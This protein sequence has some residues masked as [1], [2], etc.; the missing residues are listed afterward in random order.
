VCIPLYTRRGI[1]AEVLKRVVRKPAVE[2][3][4]FSR[5]GDYRTF[6]LR[7]ELGRVRCPTLVL[8]GRDDPITPVRGAE[9]VVEH[10]PPEVMR[11]ECL[12]DAGHG[13]FW[14][15]PDDVVSIIKRFLSDL[16]SSGAAAP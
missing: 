10:L 6:D 15:R 12:D 4:Y 13:V 16:P 7:P 14:D 2:E 1:P 3:S 11:F 9:E 5:G 8:A